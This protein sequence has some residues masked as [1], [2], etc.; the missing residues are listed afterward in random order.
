MGSMARG[1][2]TKNSEKRACSKA[3]LLVNG[4]WISASSSAP[5]GIGMQVGLHGIQ[6]AGGA[7]TILVGI[8][9]CHPAK[10]GQQGT[11]RGERDRFGA[12]VPHGSPPAD[13]VL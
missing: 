13:S 9:F 10:F 2:W 6:A 12:K 5:R 11:K 7:V 8:S 4:S 3:G 1:W